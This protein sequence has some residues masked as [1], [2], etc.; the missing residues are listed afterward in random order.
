MTKKQAYILGLA[1]FIALLFWVSIV[2]REEVATA[3]SFI[4]AYANKHPVLGVFLFMAFAAASVLL[5]PFTS[6]P[7]IP[8]GVAV[9]GSFLTTVFLLAGWLMGDILAYYIGYHFGY[10]VVGKIVGREKLDKWISQIADRLKFLLVV[11][12]RLALPSET[13]YIF[14]I[15]KYNFKKYLAA[16]FLGELPFA[17]LLVYASDAFLKGNGL[18]LAGVAVAAVALILASAWIL[19]RHSR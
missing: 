16:V 8:I 10:P 12:F 2:F 17:I 11:L 3:V 4:D 7:V 14:G 6:T 1:G 13:G 15:L 18:L 5:G 9:W 19:K